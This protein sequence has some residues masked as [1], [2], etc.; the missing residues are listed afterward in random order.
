MTPWIPRPPH[1]D[2]PACWSWPVPPIRDRDE[3]IER[4]WLAQEG[5]PREERLS[6][7]A[8]GLLFRDPAAIQWSEFHSGVRGLDDGPERCA[9]CGRAGHR[10][11]VDDHDHWTGLVRG[12]LCRGC[13]ISEGSAYGSTD[14]VLSYHEHNPASILGYR[15][16]YTGRGWPAGWYRDVRRARALTGNPTWTP[17][18]AI[19]A[20]L[21]EAD[22]EQWAIASAGMLGAP[23]QAAITPDVE[24]QQQ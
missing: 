7:G 16:F 11:L 6:V 9:L 13:N 23:P 2:E 3:E 8:L 21:G 19:G 24:G 15:R 5:L 17:D 14:G 18:I 4:A 1:P 10:A 12:L 20:T 22:A